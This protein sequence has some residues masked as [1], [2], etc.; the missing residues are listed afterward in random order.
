MFIL[1]ERLALINTGFVSILNTFL[2]EKIRDFFS[3]LDPIIYNIKKFKLP[4]LI[5][6]RC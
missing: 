5:K 4:L 6:V 2:N 1:Y 3:N